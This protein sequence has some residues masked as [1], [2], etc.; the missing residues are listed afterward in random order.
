MDD[1]KNCPVCGCKMRNKHDVSVKFPNK[2]SSLTTR[3]CTGTNHTL[4]IFSD[5][6]DNSVKIFK[7]SLNPK[8]TKFVEINYVTGT[9]D[10]RCFKE[11]I[12][13]TLTLNKILEPDLPTLEKLKKK[14]D[15]Y[16][17]FS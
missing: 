11:G 4:Q 9:T 12:E 15:L 10:I 3:L 2:I 1:F 7:V 6:K 8:Y 17:V 14:V 13:R 16:V 5:P